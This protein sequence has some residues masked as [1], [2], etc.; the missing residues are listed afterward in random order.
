MFMNKIVSMTLFK[1]TEIMLDTQK[2]VD[3]I[4]SLICNNDLEY[5]LVETMLD[6]DYIYHQIIFDLKNKHPNIKIIQVQEI[7][8]VTCAGN[9]NIKSSIKPEFDGLVEL[10]FCCNN[11]N[12]HYYFVKNGLKCNKKVSFE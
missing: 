3:T 4:D 2:L 11:K 9:F 10:G 1:F 12:N 8:N 6:L 5:I 7:E